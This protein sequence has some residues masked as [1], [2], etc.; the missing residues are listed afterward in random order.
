MD[1]FL[2]RQD[3]LVLPEKPYSSGKLEFVALL[4]II[5]SESFPHNKAHE[6]KKKFVS[7]RL[8]GFGRIPVIDSNKNSKNDI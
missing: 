1:S 7:V 8:S 3:L 5:R 4:K 2:R 6:K